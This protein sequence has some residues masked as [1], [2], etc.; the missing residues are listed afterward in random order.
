MPANTGCQAVVA[1]SARGNYRLESTPR[2]AVMAKQSAY[3]D[4][5]SPVQVLLI[6][7]A[8]GDP[9]LQGWRAHYTTLGGCRAAKS[10]DSTEQY[11][12]SAAQRRRRVSARDP[13]VEVSDRAIAPLPVK[14]G[15]DRP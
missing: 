12:G 14:P 3:A 8:S 6:D 4:D 7:D 2:H 13:H 15:G 5:M 1:R 10:Y 9:D 11:V